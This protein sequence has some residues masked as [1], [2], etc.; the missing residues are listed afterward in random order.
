M[1]QS[2][3]LAVVVQGLLSLVACFM[4]IWLPVKC[5]LF[6]PF[7]FPFSL[8]PTPFPSCL[9][10][11]F[12]LVFF[13]VSVSLL[14]HTLVFPFASLYLFLF[15]WPL[16]AFFNVFPTIVPL[17]LKEVWMLQRRLAGYTAIRIIL[18][19]FREKISRIVRPECFE[20]DE[21]GNVVFSP[22][23]ELWVVM[24]QTH[25]SGPDVGLGRATALEDLEELIN[26]RPSREERH[27]GGHFGKDTTDTPHVNGC[28]VPVGAE[29]QFWGSVPESDDLKGVWAVGDGRQPGQSEIS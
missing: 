3:V 5:S 6:S 1:L 16:P 27:T 2:L 17:V 21:F 24:W 22:L 13:P 18:K 8:P 23:R 10:L 12:P 7:P 14:L 29:Q 15:L 25:H 9:F 11:V 28:A 19:K 26:V 4:C 20:R